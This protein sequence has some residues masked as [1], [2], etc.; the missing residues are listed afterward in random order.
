MRRILI[1]VVE[2]EMQDIA[3]QA[4]AREAFLAGLLSHPATPDGCELPWPKSSWMPLHIEC[5]VNPVN[6]MN[7]LDSKAFGSSDTVNLKVRVKTRALSAAPFAG[8]RKEL[9]VII[10]SWQGM[11][12]LTI[13]P[14]I[15]G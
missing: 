5:S 13:L 10:F 6:F 2:E 1:H 4:A 11:L 3:K 12:P 8:R 14:S 7:F 15:R 9:E